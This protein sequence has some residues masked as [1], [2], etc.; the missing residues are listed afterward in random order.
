GLEERVVF[1]VLE[2]ST[3]E[4]LEERVVFYVLEYS[5]VEVL[6]ERQNS[7][8]MECRTGEKV[9]VFLALSAFLSSTGLCVCVCVLVC[10]CACVCVCKCVCVVLS[11]IFPTGIRGK[12]VSVVSAFNW[13]TNLIISMTFLT[14][15]GTHTPP[16][17]HNQ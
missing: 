12:A 3:V 16:H 14:L 6:E 15:T 4:V 8:Q 9:G 13:A 2:Y 10:V 7:A 11:E 5:T 17:T 1:Y